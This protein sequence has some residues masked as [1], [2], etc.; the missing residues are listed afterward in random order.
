MNIMNETIENVSTMLKNKQISSVELV[1]DSLSKIEAT[2]E[3]N[4]L[5]EVC[6][7]SALQKAQ[8]IDD[9]R[10]K[11]QDLP[12]LAGVPIVIKDNISMVGTFTTCSS[13]FLENY[14]SP[15]NATVVDKLLNAGA[16]IVGKA[17]MDEF[18]MGSSSETC[19]FGPVHNPRNPEYVP[20]GSSGGSAG[21]VAGN[22]CFASLGTDTGGSIRQPSSFCGVVG[23]K[24]TY[25]LVSR[26]GVVAFASSLDQVGPITKSVRDSAIMLDT[27]AGYDA[28]E[29][30]SAKH[31]TEHYYENS[32]KNSVKGM[33]IGFAKEFFE[34]LQNQEVLQSVMNAIDFFKSN[35][36]EIVDIKLPHI[37]D[38]LAVYYVLSSAE[39]AS[40]LARFDGIKY[41][42][43]TTEYKDLIDFYVQ[44]RTQGFGKEVKRRIMLGNFVLSS[45]Y[46][47]AYYNKAKAVQNL[48]INEFTDAFKQCD[49]I[50]SP[51]TPSPAFKIGEKVD[52]PL[53]MYL[54]DIYTVPVNIA[55]LPAMSIPC[56]VASNG[57][58]LGLQLIG[59]RFSESTLFNI[60]DY[61]EKNCF[62]L[63]EVK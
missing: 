61:F 17:N 30:T 56:G 13:K 27:I 10:A 7:E 59:N 39:A 38:A 16:I 51:T 24:P 32:F 41:G 43:A 62:S 6:S 34:S 26:Y 33:K 42:V 35:G 55:R 37:N 3:L 23:L 48:I 58:P 22:Q 60:S 20:G 63:R 1:K 25:G 15:Y 19:A 53:E 57:L 36:A 54:N 46:F 40:N 31:S 52:N 9:L 50:I 29:F 45:G 2:K 5:H 11:G 44:S 47:D 4:T 8:E 21:T 12:I 49:V 28:N 14:K 18:A